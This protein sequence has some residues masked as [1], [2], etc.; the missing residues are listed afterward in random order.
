MAR[1]IISS[2]WPHG[3]FSTG[4]LSQMAPPLPAASLG[5]Q[6][7][8]STTSPVAPKAPSHHLTEPSQEGQA[9]GHLLCLFQKPTP[10]PIGTLLLHTL[11][12]R[13][14]GGRGPE[15]AQGPDYLLRPCS[16]PL[17][18]PPFFLPTSAQ[19]TLQMG[20]A[21]SSQSALS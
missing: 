1:P 6:L 2:W 19:L 14:G 21:L 11:A 10:Y 7:R 4:T 17:W 8:V 12:S 18:M 9:E 5:S 20:L 3:V 13:G 15:G 16:H